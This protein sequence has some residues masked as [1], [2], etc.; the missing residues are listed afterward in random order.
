MV[1]PAK[2]EDLIYDNCTFPPTVPEISAGIAPHPFYFSFI[3]RKSLM[4]A[5]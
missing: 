3:G 2:N 5:L 1:K 4:I